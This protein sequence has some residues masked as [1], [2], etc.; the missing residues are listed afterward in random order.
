MRGTGSSNGE[1]SDD[2]ALANLG[3]ASH[4]FGREQDRDAGGGRRFADPFRVISAR[5]R[6]SGHGMT[7]NVL[8]GSDA[9]PPLFKHDALTARADPCRVRRGMAADRVAAAIQLA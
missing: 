6:S 8:Q 9:A 5:N 2:V 3:N 4:G 7:K 1:A